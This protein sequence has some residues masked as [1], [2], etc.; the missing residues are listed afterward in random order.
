MRYI[1]WEQT[2]D[3]DKGAD[4]GE[5]IMWEQTEERERQ[6]SRRRLKAQ[7]RQRW[8]IQ[9]QTAVR[10]TRADRGQKHW[11]GKSER[12]CSRQKRET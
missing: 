12:H 5:V 3:R 7:R 2:E 8:E 1:I 9:E 6:R 10:D 4:R 11:S